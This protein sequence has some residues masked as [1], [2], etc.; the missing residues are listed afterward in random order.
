MEP[1]NCMV[2]RVLGGSLASMPSN[3]LDKELNIRLANTSAF[4][5]VS[6]TGEESPKEERQRARPAKATEQTAV[7]SWCV[8]VVWNI[9][10]NSSRVNP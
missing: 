5:R 9:S 4:S 7:F 6:K 8:A 10:K 3:E 2:A 1:I